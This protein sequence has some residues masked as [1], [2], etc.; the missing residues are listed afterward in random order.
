MDTVTER[1]WLANAREYLRSS[2]SNLPAA[3]PNIAQLATAMCDHAIALAERESLLPETWR[4]R[5]AA[6]SAVGMQAGRLAR[7]TEHMPTTGSA[8]SLVKLLPGQRDAVLRRI[9]DAAIDMHGPGPLNPELLAGV[10]VP[11]T[12]PA[13]F[14]HLAESSD[15][16]RS[17]L[18]LEVEQTG[19][20]FIHSPSVVATP[21]DRH[22]S[23]MRL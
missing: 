1:H 22:F 10:P 16:S 18:A 23:G 11:Y 6:L 9:I 2:R 5:G 19:R 15:R 21:Q 14:D 3:G 4:R 7:L 12:T 17:E 20:G 8:A 13:E